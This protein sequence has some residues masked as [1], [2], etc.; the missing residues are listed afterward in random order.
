MKTQFLHITN[1]FSKSLSQDTLIKLT[2]K[3]VI[4]P[5]YHTVSS[6]P[7][8]H[9]SEL[10]Y[11][12]TEKQFIED[13]N[14]FCQYFETVQAG[15]FDVSKKQFHLSFDD[16]M[17]EMYD[18]VFPILKE[19]NIHA[20]FF[21]N[22]D[23]VDNKK[24]FISHKKSLIKSEI[25]NFV[26]NQ[27]LLSEYLNIDSSRLHDE[28]SKVSSDEKVDEI[29]RKIGI[30]FSAYLSDNKPY[31]TTKQ[32]IEL[33]NAGFTIGNHGR[34][35]RNFNTLTFEEQ[36]TE[37]EQVNHFL[38]EIGVEKL[39]FA[40]PYGDHQIKN[41]LFDWMYSEGIIHHSF[42]VSG[43]KIDGYPQHH[44]RI[45]MEQSRFS[46]EEIVKA[47]YFYYIWKSFVFRNK[48]RR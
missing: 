37:I 27:N 48:I 16:G 41:K 26:Q 20:T 28:I 11:F 38:T 30:D 23:F 43:L 14:Y 2:G 9:F 47:E 6:D 36:K 40:F 7:A 29:A 5:F 21:I 17:S 8:P 39:F 34:S 35:H 18:V 25:K 45:L 19:R 46:A 10:S 3:K 13:L 1:S 4:L 32:I 15:I 33:K 44:H 12:R 31:L 42:G 22:T 24:M